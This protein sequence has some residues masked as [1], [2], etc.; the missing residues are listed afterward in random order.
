[1]TPYEIL[2]PES[3]ERMPL[4]ADKGRE[5][6]VFAVFKKWGLEASEI[7]IVTDDGKLRVRHHGEIVAEIPNRE[8]ADEAPLYDRP[9]TTPMRKA[10]V[11]PPTRL[12]I[13]DVQAALPTLLAAPDICSKRWI[14]QQYDYQV[15]TNTITIPEKTDAAIVRIKETGSS[16]AMSLD[17]NG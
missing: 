4:L 13:A 12:P 9:H 6:E 3:P 1:M 2:L 14:W 16:I 10:P 17:G 8:L 15:R 5:D 7:G 11:D